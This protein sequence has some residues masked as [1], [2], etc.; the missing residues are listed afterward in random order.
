MILVLFLVIISAVLSIILRRYINATFWIAGIAG[1]IGWSISGH[2]W[3]G[4]I[5]GLFS[6]GG[7]FKALDFLGFEMCGHCGSHDTKKVEDDPHV[8]MWKC[9]KCGNY[10]CQSE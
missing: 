5:V 2:W 4:L 1:M 6:L 7:G 3:I 10:T 9:N 8:K